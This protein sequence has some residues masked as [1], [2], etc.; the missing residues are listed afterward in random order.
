MKGPTPDINRY[1]QVLTFRADGW[2]FAAI[3][4]FYGISA[5]A[6]EK[7]VKRA[8]AWAGKSDLQPADDLDEKLSRVSSSIMSK[9][10]EIEDR[11][12]LIQH[13]TEE[14]SAK[15]QGVGRKAL[16]PPPTEMWTWIVNECAEEVGESGVADYVGTERQHVILWRRGHSNPRAQHREKLKELMAT[17]WARALYAEDEQLFELRKKKVE[18]VR[19]VGGEK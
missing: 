8:Q 17:I 19:S 2:T 15:Q 7:L 14:G 11:L 4:K 10:E 13:G 6:A 18:R 16:K 5:S 12:L 9:L 1:E 3:G